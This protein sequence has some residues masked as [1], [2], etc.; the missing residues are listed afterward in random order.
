MRKKITVLALFLAAFCQGVK[1]QIPLVYTVENTG[2]GFAPP[3]LP[4]FDQLPA[5]EPLTDPFMWSDGSGRSTSF[6]DWAR[7]RNEIRAE[8]EHYEIGTKPSRPETITASFAPGTN[9]GVLTVHVMVNGQTLTLTSQVI[10]PAGSGPFPAVIG[11]NS[12]NGS[13]PADI[14]S[15]RNIA[16][17]A[18]NANQVT[19]YGN[20]RITDP[21]FRLY[22]GQNLENSGQYSAWAWGVSRIIDGLELV[23]ASLPIDLSHLAVTGCSYAGKMALF[24]GA[25]DERIALTIAQESGGGGAPA[26]RVSETLG[27]VEKLGATDYRWFRDDMRQFAGNNVAKLPHDH[28]E[29]M[30]MIAPRALLVTGNTDFEWL[31]NPAAYV[32]ARATHE[33]YKTLGIGDRF[34]F[35]IDGGHGHCAIPT[36]QR[37]AIEAFVDKFLLSKPN[38]NTNITTHPYDG[39]DYQRWYKWW[40]TGNPVLPAEP[41]GK[42]IWLEAECATVGSDWEVVTDAAAANGSYVTVKSG[43]NS[44]AAAPAG[45]SGAVVFPF[46]VDSAATYNFVAR[47]NAPTANDDSYWIKIDNGPFVTVNGLATSGW[48]WLRVSSAILGVGPH[49]ITIAYRE[50]GAHL[51]KLLVTTSGASITGLGAP[52]LNCGQAPVITPAQVFSIS[53]TAALNAVIGSVGATDAD[54][55]SV[56]QNWQITG[57]T[58]AGAFA[59][60]AHTGQLRVLDNAAFDFESATRSFTLSLTV[61]DGYFTS[62]AETVTIHLTN[63]NDNAPVVSA[64]MSFA[65]DGGICSELGSMTATDLD[66]TQE[67]GFTTLQNWQIVGGTGVGIFGINPATG[68]V[69]IQNLAQADLSQSAFTLSVTVSDGLNTSEPQTVTVTI[70]DKITVCHKGQLI[71]VSKMAA[72]G[73]LQHGDCI[74]TC[75]NEVSSAEALAAKAGLQGAIQIYPNPS[76]DKIE[77]NLGANAQNIRTIQVLELS[78]K[79]VLEIAAGNASAVS[80]P[81]KHL[82]AGT[83]L[84]RMQ[85]DQVVTQRIVVQ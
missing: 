80:I 77:I 5:I 25:L 7:R 62:A 14:F 57:G 8:I 56:L 49:T 46:T 68:M 59:V 79:V 21:Y 32:S 65:L 33:V 85:G 66:D 44:T 30:A 13:V 48:Q 20:P 47:L 40:G 74:G 42:R 27:S 19:T 51:D 10:L 29:L 67:P 4:S 22:P 36:T 2:S 9:G 6:S 34:G 60:D 31:A 53:E 15:S 17:I 38:V 39:I 12:Q 84:V 50:D 70:P 83:Y 55:G 61:T 28:H 58:G 76:T 16:R 35:Y 52:G 37:P 23:Q 1:A 41:L 72:M 71:S 82:R 78:G 73:H 11:M 18:F 64:G 81:G 24:S 45:A 63:A 54:A 26:W 69:S 3:P 75:G 43:L